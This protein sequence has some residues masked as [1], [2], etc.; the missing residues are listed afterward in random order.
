MGSMPLGDAYSAR[1]D[2][3]LGCLPSVE[4]EAFTVVTCALQ[5][6]ASRFWSEEKNKSSKEMG[7]EDAY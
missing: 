7:K 1:N 5:L 6:P 4:A 3:T 2:V